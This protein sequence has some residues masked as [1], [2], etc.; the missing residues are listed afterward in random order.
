MIRS[1]ATS[2]F[3]SLGIEYESTIVDAASSRPRALASA[4][5]AAAQ[6]S[7]TRGGVVPD[8]YE[9]TLEFSTGICTTLN[10]AR[11]DLLGTFR[12]VQPLLENKQ[13]YLVGM[14]LPPVSHSKDFDFADTPRYAEIRELLQWTAY[15][16]MT[17]GIHVHVGMTSLAQ[18][19]DTTRALRTFLPV[20]LA[21][22]ASSPF[23][24][25]KTTGLA[26]TRM[27]LR[28]S[29]PR[30]G[31][32]PNF[33]SVGEYE[34]YIDAMHA[35]GAITSLRDLRWDCRVNAELG[36]VE[37]RIIDTIAD[38]DDALA[39]CALA[40]SLAVA[41]PDLEKHLLPATLSDENMWRATRYGHRSAFLIDATGATE[42]IGVV[43]ERLVESLGATADALGCRKELERCRDFGWGDAPHQRLT[44]NPEAVHDLDLAHA[45]E[46][47]M[48]VAW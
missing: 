1:F 18:A 45:A 39:L 12:A 20:L 11:A 44:L 46:L 47:A 42:P 22:S 25:G 31:P 14:G 30:T 4:L 19:L 29:I 5:S 10:Q 21:L 37:I 41:A 13:A 16:V 7:V 24:H 28:S 34:S 6:P 2:T 26:S 40:W 3:G 15:R 36:T 33:E 8:F 48:R 32:M 38:L 35:A 23:R 17:N 9:G 43:T 27:A